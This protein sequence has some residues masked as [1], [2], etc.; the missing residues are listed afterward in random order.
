M[1]KIYLAGPMTGLPDLN[2]PAF[3]DTARRLRAAGFEVVSPA[4]LVPDKS[5]PWN[6]AL[7]ADLIAMLACE[8]IAL[9]P[10]WHKSRGATI[11][12][13]LA[14]DVGMDIYSAEALAATPSL[15]E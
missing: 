11:E 1:K 8:G 7:R 12:H 4:E 15:A 9:M 14:S 5:T 6:V 10:G 3:H 13:K 2:F